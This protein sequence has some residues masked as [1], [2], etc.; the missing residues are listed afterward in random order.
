MKASHHV[1]GEPEAKLMRTVEGPS[2]VAYNVQ[3]AVDAEHK[4]VV[5]HEVINEA[6]DNRSLLPMATGAKETLGT[7]TLNVAADTGYSNGEQIKKCEEAGIT[8][9]LPVQRAVNTQGEYFE[10]AAFSYD[11][12]ADC[13]RCPAGELLRRKTVNNKDRLV[14]YTTERCGGCVLKA[15]CTGAKQ[16]FVTRHFDE[17]VLQ[18]AQRRLES[19]PQAMALRRETVEH[20]FA[21]LKY[22]ILGRPRLLLR[23]LSG[24]RAEIA[25]AV[26]AY[27]FG[28]AMRLLGTGAMRQKLVPG[29]A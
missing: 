17:E 10:R 6:F 18:R 7:P 23:G 25:L 26:L 15:Q 14:V 9:Y 27:N 1:V 21:N 29:P 20:P 22:A 3:T 12:A 16:R 11:A 13:Y 5:H 2:V 4:L 24:A 19:F 28:K 8:P